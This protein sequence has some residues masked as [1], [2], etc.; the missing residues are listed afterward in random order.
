MKWR[1][2]NS[3]EKA[4]YGSAVEGESGQVNQ[5]SNDMG[6]ITRCS[7]DRFHRTVQKMSAEKRLT[8]N[9][10]GFG[11]L[12]S[13][14][15]TRLHRQLCKFLIERFNPETSSI[16]L[17]GNVFGISALDF[18][19]VMGLKNTGEAVELGCSDEKVKELVKRFG[20]N[21]KRVLVSALADQLEKCEKADEDFKVGFVMFA[22]GTVLCPSSSLSVT[23]K[24][25]NFLTI[26]GKIE[27]KNWADH[28]FNFLREGV[29]LFKAKEVAYVNG[30]L[31][32]LQL[33][34]FDSIVHGGVYVD[35]SVDPILS[36]D[37]NLAWKL[38]K[39]VR[40]QGGFDSLTV[41]VVSRR[42]RRDEVSAVNIERIVEEV[43]ISLA[44]IIQG[45]VKRSVEGLAITLG[46]IIQAHVQRSVSELTEKVMSVKDARQH[47][48]PGPQHINE[49]KEDGAVKKTDEGGQ[50]V[51]T[52]KDEECTKLPEKGAVHVNN[53]STPVVDGQSCIDPEV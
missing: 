14:A 45:E 27:S 35:K 44:P 11:N 46:P 29:R 12:S 49:S 36:W 2:L 18:G 53:L 1:E 47:L 38:I 3:K 52:K 5:P 24:Y 15:C 20:A 25:L 19:R 42:S 34:Y 23:G 48:P 51:M 8:V 13:L 40:K 4:T 33:F 16:E 50:N 41:R 10:I 43:V 30:S 21:G 9:A 22:L 32:F 28:A 7:P 39:W 17:H 6:F 26:P 37:N 31:L